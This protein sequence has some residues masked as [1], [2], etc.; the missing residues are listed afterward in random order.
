MRSRAFAGGLSST[1]AI[2]AMV[3]GASSAVAGPAGPAVEVAAGMTCTV[4][5]GWWS[6]D[7]QQPIQPEPVKVLTLK[8][9]VTGTP[10]AWVQPLRGKLADQQLQLALDRLSDCR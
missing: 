5:D 3:L 8:A 6:L 7:P 1:L 10:G 9:L 4:R 2:A